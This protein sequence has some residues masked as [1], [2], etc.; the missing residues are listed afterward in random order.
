MKKRAL[1]IVMAAMVTASMIPMTAFASFDVE[2]EFD[3]NPEYEKYTVFEYTLEALS[4]DIVVTLCAKGEDEYEILTNF[5]GDDQ[6]WVGTYDGSAVTTTSDKTGF[7]EGDAPAI[8]QAGI[9][10]DNW[11][12]IGEEGAADDAAAETAGE[13]VDFGVEPEFEAKEGYPIFTVLEYTI[14]ELST[15]IIA[16]VSA[17]EEF[18]DFDIQCNFYG[19]DQDWEGT[20]DADAETVETKA[21]KTG[22]MEGD[23]PAIIKA[24]IEK[25]LWAWSADGTSIKAAPA[26]DAAADD[27]AAGDVTVDV[28][29]EFDPN[30][31]YDKYTVF[32]YTLEA[33]STD[34][35]VTLCAKGEDEYEILTN[36][37]GDDQDWV[38]TYDGSAV[39]T[40]SDK[41]GFME[42]DAPAIIQAGIDADNWAP[43]Q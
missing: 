43:I 23:A 41:T 29:P 22:F 19:D 33:L 34:I 13:P 40:T 16:T 27:A 10:A 42:G 35:V 2:P 36:F 4:T 25:D 12:A 28:E 20:Y 7:M 26:D 15:D 1:A 24:A 8:I 9:D 32:E 14:E 17:N 6:D 37:Y 11:V 38:G 18:T 30:P 5:Y 31:D 3:P 21:D 39:T